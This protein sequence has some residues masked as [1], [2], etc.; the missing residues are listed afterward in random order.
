MVENNMAIKNIKEKELQRESEF[1][2]RI[3]VFSFLVMYLLAVFF[4]SSVMDV[5]RFNIFYSHIIF[6]QLF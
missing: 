2:K 6:N 4:I 1:E 3:I 5:R